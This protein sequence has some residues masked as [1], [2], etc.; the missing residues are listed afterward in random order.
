MKSSSLT[1]ACRDGALAVHRL[2]ATHCPSHNGLDGVRP[3]SGVVARLRQGLAAEAGAVADL[4]AARCQV[5]EAVSAARAEGACY[6]Q[7]ATA[8]V[9][10]KGDLRATA[11]ARERVAG[12]LRSRMHEARCRT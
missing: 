12:N 4:R 5:R 11:R 6:H 8:I 10:P 9:P 3:S 7:I 1:A 2:P